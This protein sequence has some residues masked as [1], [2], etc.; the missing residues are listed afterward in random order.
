MT[1]NS[2]STTE[3]DITTVQCLSEHATSFAVLVDVAGGLKVRKNL[4]ELA[5][6]IIAN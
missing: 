4:N 6:I 5:I 3:D 2:S 1:T